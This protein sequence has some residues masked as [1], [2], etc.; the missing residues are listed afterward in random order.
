LPPFFVDFVLVS[1]VIEIKEMSADL[2][3]SH[4]NEFDQS[5]TEL[6]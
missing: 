4:G 5:K 6:F 2:M 3:T 1:T